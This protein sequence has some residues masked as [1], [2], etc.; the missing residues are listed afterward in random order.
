MADIFSDLIRNEF[1][2]NL[3]PANASLSGNLVASN[4]SNGGNI[5]WIKVFEWVGVLM[6][7]G[8]ASSQFARTPKN[9]GTKSTPANGSINNILKISE[10]YWTGT[11]H[12]L[13]AQL[14]FIGHIEKVF[15]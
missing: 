2:S 10:T 9:A 6:K 8:A 3:I 4:C 14:T 7:R 13:V 15:Q 11:H 5:L 1:T 12:G